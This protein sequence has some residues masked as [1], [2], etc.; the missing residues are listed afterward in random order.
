MI[1]LGVTSKSMKVWLGER[2]IFKRYFSA[3]EVYVNLYSR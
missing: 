3:A 2:G 1:Y